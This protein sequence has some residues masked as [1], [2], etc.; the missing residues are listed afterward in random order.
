MVYRVVGSGERPLE[1]STL[2]AAAAA[3]AMIERGVRDVRVLGG[4]G[5]EIPAARWRQ[6]GLEPA[7][8]RLSGCRRFD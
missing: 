7:A 1:A 5:G 4:D 8:K 6:A 2:A 3:S